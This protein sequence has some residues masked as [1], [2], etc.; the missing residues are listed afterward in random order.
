MSS[1][2]GAGRVRDDPN[3]Y[4]D[5]KSRKNYAG[6]SPITLRHETGPAGPLRPNRRL[7]DACYLWAFAALTAGPRARAFY[8]HRRAAGDTHHGA[9]RAGKAHGEAA[10]GL[11]HCQ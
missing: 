3:R 4:C 6:T 11:S 8:N 7:A 10:A 1:R 5:A 9:L 2:P